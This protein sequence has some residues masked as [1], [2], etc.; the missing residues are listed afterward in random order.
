[1]LKAY[2]NLASITILSLAFIMCQIR[3]DLFV[4]GCWTKIVVTPCKRGEYRNS[5]T[6]VT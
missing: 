2:S 3:I 4:N 1:M 5:T 6:G